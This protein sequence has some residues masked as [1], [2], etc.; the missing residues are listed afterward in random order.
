MN[1]LTFWADEVA[2][3]ASTGSAQHKG[4]KR[5]KA[6]GPISAER[7]KRR[8]AAAA[9]RQAFFA[10]LHYEPNYAYP[11]LIW[12]PGA[13]GDHRQLHRVM[14]HVSV[15]NY[16][17]ASIRGT[18]ECDSEGNA[19][20]F[21]QSATDILAAE[22][23]VFSAI[24][25]ACEKFNISRSRVFLAGYADGGTMALRIGLRRPESFAAALS[26]GGPF[27]T[28]DGNEPAIPGQ[29][30]LA[31]LS[32]ARRLPLFIAQGR[33]STDYPIDTLC[34]ELRLFHAAGMSVTVRQY[35]CGDELDSQMLVDM[36][37]WIMEHV[38]GNTHAPADTLAAPGSNN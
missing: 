19:A 18:I 12:L 10:P 37:V 35:P 2:A 16:A 28:P 22:E 14:P 24:D 23:A 15:R 36:N 21:T 31:R 32:A 6:P 25:Q 1:R 30:P 5:R 20:S 4:K 7:L 11:L 8:Q 27:P 38:T 29:G 13:G 34:S 26:V 17:A 9:E 33:D 3:A